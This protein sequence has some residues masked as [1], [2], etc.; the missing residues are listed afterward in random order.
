MMLYNPVVIPGQGGAGWL[1]ACHTRNKTVDQLVTVYDLSDCMSSFT[2]NVDVSHAINYWLDWPS[3]N[4]DGAGRFLCQHKY[5]SVILLYRVALCNVTLDHFTSLHS[6]TVLLGVLQNLN[7][8]LGGLFIP[9]AY[10]TATRQYVAQA[11]GWSLEEL[12][13]DVSTFHIVYRFQ[14]AWDMTSKQ[15]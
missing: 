10:I 4:L 14:N 8:W 9:E 13:L 1:H 15:I 12:Y 7:V 5:G 6:H 2:D 3:L 11:N